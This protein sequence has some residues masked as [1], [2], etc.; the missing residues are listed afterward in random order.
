[1]FIYFAHSCMIVV[2][3]FDHPNKIVRDRDRVQAHR[4]RRKFRD[5]SHL[6]VDSNVSLHADFMQNCHVEPL[7]HDTM[8]LS[9]IYSAQLSFVYVFLLILE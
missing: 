2:V 5:P 3:N 4:R 8:V 7:L 6:Q 1:M 9:A